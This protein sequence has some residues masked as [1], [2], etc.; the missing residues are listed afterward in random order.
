V[1]RVLSKNHVEPEPYLLP[2]LR[3]ADKHGSAFPSLLWA[4]PQTQAARFDAIERLGN[5]D[6]KS[7][8][9]VGCGRADLLE[10]LLERG[11]RPA[12]YVG[13]EAVE[14]L[15]AAAEAKCR[16]LPDASVVRADFVR[17]PTRM[18]VAADVVVF[19]GSLNTVED[20]DFY[21]TL[22][23]AFDAAAESVVFNF[24][25]HSYLAGAD[26]L[27]WHRADDVVAFANTLTPDV[28]TLDDYL[29]GDFTV[30]MCKKDS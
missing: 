12:D 24:L 6:G 27:R 3:A 28:R 7:V 10:F 5:L 14:E 13:I 23:R 15:A 19:S 29:H 26:Y 2:Y 18:F 20:E 8:L 1:G 16:R 11:V 9:D 30:A 17:E 4:S 25:C 21:R 22:H